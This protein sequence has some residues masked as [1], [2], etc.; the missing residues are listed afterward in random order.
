MRAGTTLKAPGVAALAA[1]ALALALAGAPDAVDLHG[2]TLRG[3]PTGPGCDRRA[4]ADLPP[5]ADR[6]SISKVLRSASKRGPSLRA[7]LLGTKPADLRIE[8]TVQV[9][10]RRAKLKTTTQRIEGPGF[11]SVQIGISRS[12]R[13]QAPARSAQ[14]RGP[15]QRPADRRRPGDHGHADARAL[16]ARS[17]GREATRRRRDVLVEAGDFRP[18]AHRASSCAS[19]PSSAWF[20]A[21][22]CSPLARRR[23]RLKALASSRSSEPSR[24]GRRARPQGAPP[25]ARARRAPVRG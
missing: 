10:G 11:T 14:G 25:V 18:S 6:Q 21:T 20:S 9:G 8:A 2:R 1:T 12:E 19:R 13:G 5:H 17:A 22:S 23:R 7:A 16:K 15:G 3:R 4:P 24:R